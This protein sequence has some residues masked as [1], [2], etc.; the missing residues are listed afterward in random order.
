MASLLAKNEIDVAN[1]ARIMHKSTRR[2]RQ[3]C[4]ENFFKT[5]HQP[6]GKN[7]WWTISRLEVMEKKLVTSL[8]TKYNP[9]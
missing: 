8:E 3:L 2:I 5:A 1:A 4:A 9:D 7:G 6:C